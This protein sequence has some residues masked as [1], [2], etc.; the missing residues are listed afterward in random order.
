MKPIITTRTIHAPLNLVFQT[1]ADVRNFRRAVPDIIKIE[2][3]SNIQHGVGTRFR[4]T[5]LMNGRE[6]TVPLEVTEFVENEHVRLVSDA[7]GTIWD[8]VFSVAE[9]GRSVE[10]EM[11]MDVRPY[12]LLARIMNVLI[13]GLVVKGVQKDMDAVKTFCETGGEPIA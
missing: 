8:T 2:F 5:R 1:V 4:E 6:A 10:L 9:V 7:G 3:Q 11:H 12:K 13:R